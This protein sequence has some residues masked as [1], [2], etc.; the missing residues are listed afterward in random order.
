MLPIARSLPVG[1]VLLAIITVIRS[2]EP[3]ASAIKVAPAI[4][5]ERFMY[6]DNL[7]M[8]IDR[9]SPLIYASSLKSTTVTSTFRY[10]GNT[11]KGM[12]ISLLS[13][14]RQKYRSK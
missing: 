8:A 13:F 5:S 12:M 6:L 14:S 10:L 2:V 4:A 11:I 9:Y 7:A 3:F 1:E